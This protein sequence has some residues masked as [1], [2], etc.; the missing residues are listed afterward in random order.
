MFKAGTLLIQGLISTKEWLW[1]KIKLTIDLDVLKE[2][3]LVVD[4]LKK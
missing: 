2:D 3:I 4:E 1:G